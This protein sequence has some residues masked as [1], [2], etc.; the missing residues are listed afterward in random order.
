MD[1]EWDRLKGLESERKHG[2]TFEEASQAF[3]DDYSMTVPDP[4][5]SIGEERFLH[6]ARTFQDKF[7]VIAFTER[8]GRI[9]IIG[10]R[11]MTR[12]ERD[13]YES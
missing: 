7:L 8:N 10:A 5:H 1:F 9:R 3:A 11:S 13:A 4:D 12:R 6:F 2:V